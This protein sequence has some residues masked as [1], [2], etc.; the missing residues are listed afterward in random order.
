MPIQPILTV[1]N[2]READLIKK[3]TSYEAQL[4]EEKAKLDFSVF[5]NDNKIMGAV[6][7]L[8][9][10]LPKSR[11]P[12]I[13]ETIAR[14]FSVI[15]EEQRRQQLPAAVKKVKDTIESTQLLL[16]ATNKELM[17]LTTK[18]GL[19]QKKIERQLRKFPNYKKN[20]YTQGVRGYPRIRDKS[21]KNIYQY[22]YIRFVMRGI[23][24]K[25]SNN[26]YKWLNNGEI[27]VIPLKDI[28]VICD[29]ATT[30]LYLS[31]GPHAEPT[32]SRHEAKTLHPH[33]MGDFKPCLGSFQAG[34]QTAITEQN[35]D[36]LF[37]LLQSFFEQANQDDSAGMHWIDFVTRQLPD[38][39]TPTASPS[40]G[41]NS[42]S[43]MRI[44]ND[45]TGNEYNAVYA[46]GVISKLTEILPPSITDYNNQW[47]IY[48]LA[49]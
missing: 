42:S 16:T 27:P 28:E 40:R 6:N 14:Y 26:P 17:L 46:D 2:P 5:E 20:S 15:K 45:D 11:N 43:L 1:S 18:Q 36:E 25:P 33:I 19:D 12:I 23:Q 34:V 9:D 47:S 30:Q 39:I 48:A 24:M 4:L 3:K 21:S 13:H 22:Q 8:M 44:T 41:D 35:I 29:I 10:A 31:W 32:S 7:D 49:A 38:D 37:L